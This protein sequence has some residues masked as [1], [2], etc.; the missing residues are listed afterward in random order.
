[1]AQ[2][3]GYKKKGFFHGMGK[4]YV[5]NHSKWR[6]YILNQLGLIEIDFVVSKRRLF[7]M[8]GDFIISVNT[9]IS[10]RV[11]YPKYPVFF[12]ERGFQYANSQRDSDK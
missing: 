10:D 1:M 11:N 8:G 5:F 7:G 12:K 6:L 9:E 2:K 3:K 4:A